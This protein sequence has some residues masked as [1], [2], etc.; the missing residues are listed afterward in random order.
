MER[1]IIYLGHDNRIDWQL[2]A[3]GEA[4][5]LEAVTRMVI[6]IDTKILDS[7]NLGGNGHGN[8]FY[9]TTGIPADG[10]ANL[11]LSLGAAASAAGVS[12]GNHNVRLT[13]YDPDHVAGLV[14]LGNEPIT[15]I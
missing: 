5:D 8:A 7:A 14:W 6:E 12:T 13:V 2:R 4:V 9:W 10:V 15:V 11:F 1:E 3:D